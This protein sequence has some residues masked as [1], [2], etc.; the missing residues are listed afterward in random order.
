MDAVCFRHP[1]AEAVTTCQN[2]GRPICTSCI[3]RSQGGIFCGEPCAKRTSTEADV[4][5][6]K[7]K[8]GYREKSIFTAFL[9][10]IAGAIALVALAEYLGWIDVL[11][12][13]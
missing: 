7:L 5:H 3:V 8:K 4:V 2:C 11:P 9:P 10:Y 12:W 6:E 1:N 13:F